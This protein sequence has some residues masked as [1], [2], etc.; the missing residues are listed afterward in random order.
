VA[1]HGSWKDHQL[2][3]APPEKR[4]HVPDMSLPIYAKKG[5]VIVTGDRLFGRL[6]RMVDPARHI[7]ATTWGE[8]LKSVL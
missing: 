1:Y 8:Y 6:F 3:A 2:N 7:G 4:D 5:N